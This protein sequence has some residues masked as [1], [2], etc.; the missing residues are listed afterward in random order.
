MLQQSISRQTLIV[1]Q[2]HTFFQ[3]YTTGEERA[4]TFMAVERWSEG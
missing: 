1:A 3:L 4:S 2:G